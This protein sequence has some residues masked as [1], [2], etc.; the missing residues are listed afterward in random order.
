[1]VLIRFSEK[2]YLSDVSI[3]KFLSG[4]FFILLGN[5]SF[6]EKGAKSFRTPRKYTR[7]LDWGSQ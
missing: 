6:V 1:M 2:I 7:S 3:R 4:G 5:M